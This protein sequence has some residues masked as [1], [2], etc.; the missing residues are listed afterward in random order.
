M[1]NYPDRFFAVPARPMFLWRHIPMGGRFDEHAAIL[2]RVHN[3]IEEKVD[4]PDAQLREASIA[5]NEVV[6]NY[7][8]YADRADE[9][10]AELWS[11]VNPLLAE[12]Q[13]EDPDVEG[14]DALPRLDR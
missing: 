14:E 6:R 1:V 2:E 11:I 4:Y 12:P 8:G 3:H 5:V 9:F 10:R 13:D 7:R